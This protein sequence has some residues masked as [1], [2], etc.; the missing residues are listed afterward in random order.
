MIRSLTHCRI[1]VM[2][3]EILFL[4]KW[5]ETNTKRAS[6]AKVLAAHLGENVETLRKQFRRKEG[7]ALS[8][9]IDDVRL[10]K[11]KQLLLTTDMLCYEVALELGMEREDAAAR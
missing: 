5:I 10:E 2:P 7:I 4:K 6:S 3:T 11:A 1:L 8:D 9:F